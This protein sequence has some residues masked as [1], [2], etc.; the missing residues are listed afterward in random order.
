MTDTTPRL[1]LPLLAAAQAQ[2]HVTHNEALVA[3]DRLVH[4]TALDR[5]NAP[6]ASPGEGDAHLVGDTPTGAFA[7]HANHVA[8]FGG[9]GWRFDAPA[10]GWILWLAGEAAALVFDGA[11]W[12]DLKARSAD[13]LGIAATADGTNRLAVASPAVLFSHAGAGAQVKVNKAAAADTASLLFQ[14]GWSGR[15]EIGTTGND[16]L[17]VK[18]SPDGTGWTEAVVVDNGGAVLL[19]HGAPVNVGA[20]SGQAVALQVH[21]TDAGTAQAG[22]YRWTNS[23]GGATFSVV[24]SRGPAPG[25]RGAVQDNDTIG[26]FQFWGDDGT[27]FP[28]AAALQVQV[29]GTP[30]PGGM[31][32]RLVLATTAAGA[33]A[34]T[35]RLRVTS[36]GHTLPGADDAYTLGSATRRWSSVW[37]VNGTIQTSDRRDKQVTGDLA[38]A[39]TM[40]D[41]VDPVLFRWQSRAD[42][43][44]ADGRPAPK[45][46]DPNT[47]A[48]RGR[49]HA[50]FLAQE[51]RA[52]MEAASVDFGAWGLDDTNDGNSRQWLRPDQ[53]VAV[54]WAALRQTR[55]QIEA[56]RSQMAVVE[57]R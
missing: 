47:T 40:V 21:G 38:F 49:Q 14:T 37:S 34:A 24:K 56:M 20:S 42:K 29:D 26:S 16:R 39:G 3:L 11:A 52:A 36:A 10:S 19:R 41:A 53:M 45:G 30:T 33:T 15:A 1:A 23:A 44:P 22:V 57:G 55:S 51:V 48:P 32:G 8:T 43:A 5:R 6:P 18:V 46:G 12:A 17:H 54:L 50:G 13:R 31:P 7:G 35:E 25:T 9:G 2:K 27:H 28:T 4:L